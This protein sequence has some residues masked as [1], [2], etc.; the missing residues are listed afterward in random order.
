MSA[1]YRLIMN[2]WLN[3]QLPSMVKFVSYVALMVK[4]GTNGVFSPTLSHTVIWVH[5][6]N[7]CALYDNLKTFLIVKVEALYRKQ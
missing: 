3:K 7:I 5:F 6:V 1:S 2:I 4:V